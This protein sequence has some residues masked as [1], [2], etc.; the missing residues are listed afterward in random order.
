MKYIITGCFRH[1]TNRYALGVTDYKKY[2]E[3][4]ATFDGPGIMNTWKKEKLHPFYNYFADKEE[5]QLI[6]VMIMNASPGPAVAQEVWE[7]VKNALVEAIDEAD[8]VDGILLGLHGAMVTEQF[9]DGEGELL[10]VLRQKVGK[11]TP[12]V[13]S[14]DLH[15][16]MTKK[17][18]D[19]ATALFAYDNYPHTDMYETDQRAA[20]CIY[21]TLEGQIHPVLCFNQQDLILPYMPTAYPAMA[22]F[23]AKA[24]SYRNNGK[25]IDVSICHGFFASDIYQQGLAV[26]AVSDGDREL[27]QK[28]ADDLAEELFAARKE[29]RREFLS[30]EEAVKIAMNSEQ[31]PVVLAEVADNPGSGASADATLLLKTLIQQGAEDVAFSLIYD[32]EVVDIAVKAGVGSTIHVKI[33]GKKVPE[34]TGGPVEC[35]AYVKYITD[36]NYRNR[37]KMNQGNIVRLGTAVLLQIDGISLVVSSFHVQTYDLE[38]YRHF[39]LRPEE[40][41]ILV[42]KSAAHFRASF[43]KVASRIID[44]ATPALAPMNPEDLPLARSR[45][46]IYPLDEI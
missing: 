10:E 28:T 16:N 14:L 33:G 27:A 17:M 11:D 8:Q 35:D 29:L 32:P 43:G 46:P 4:E 6:P 22:P 18:V 3:R 34:L 40:M 30:A 44:V 25:M 21:R 1:E 31:Y 26:I 20:D 7:M 23:C 9:E 2:T 36:G 41:K 13:A 42:V 38:V 39:G 37:D 15:A 45:R 19:N 24:Q 12:I 5:Y